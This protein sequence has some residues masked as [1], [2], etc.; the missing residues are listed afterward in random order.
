[1]QLKHN[2]DMVERDASGM[3]CNVHMHGGGCGG[4][5]ESSALPA[6]GGSISRGR[7]LS[8]WLQGATSRLRVLKGGDTS[9]PPMH[10]PVAT[11][12]ATGDCGP[13]WRNLQKMDGGI[14]EQKWEGGFPSMHVGAADVGR[15]GMS[16]GMAVLEGRSLRA[17]QSVPRRMRLGED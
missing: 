11:G 15:R 2:G 4:A 13:L 14:T 16:R 6:Q 7:T 10:A 9:C 12:V 17:S 5:G 8:R 1:M 3:R